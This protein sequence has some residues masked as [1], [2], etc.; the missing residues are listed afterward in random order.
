MPLSERDYMR[1]KSR[2][3]KT[4]TLGHDQATAHITTDAYEPPVTITRQDY[5]R[6]EREKRKQAQATQETQH[7]RRWFTLM[8]VTVLIIAVTLIA[9]GLSLH[10]F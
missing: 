9:L 1:T 4:S 2:S 3:H 8:L 5:E 10:L 6:I 7:R